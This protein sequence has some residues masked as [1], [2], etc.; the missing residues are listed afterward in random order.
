MNYRNVDNNSQK[1]S[2]F[3]DKLVNFTVLFMQLVIVFVAC[4]LYL[5]GNTELA[6]AVAFL[7]I[8]VYIYAPLCQLSIYFSYMRGVKPYIERIA[9]II[10][11]EPSNVNKPLELSSITLDNLS[12]KTDSK[13]LYDDVSYTFEIGKK[14]LLRGESG[15]GKTSLLNTLIGY[16]RDYDGSITFN[17][18]SENDLSD[19]DLNSYISYCHQEPFLFIGSLLD[20]ITM[21]DE[22]PNMERV[23][24]LIKLCKLDKFAEIR[25]LNTLLDNNE[26]AISIGEMQRISLAR[27]LYFD[28]PVLFLDEVTSSVDAENANDIFDVIK[29]IKGKLII[30]ISHQSEV[31]SL[32]WIDKSL[33]LEN[34]KLK[35]CN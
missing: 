35:E 21:Y 31:E 17:S 30:W 16:N 20:N 18:L 28:K 34:R 22:K 25:G 5:N 24:E 11:S 29:N 10:P 14:Y 13:T 12:I 32:D 23:N 27:A 4:L 3:V 8:S 2:S 15:T 1:F 19:D 6:I 7:Q 33:L 26:N 9:A